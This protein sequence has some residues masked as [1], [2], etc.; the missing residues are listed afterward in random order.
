MIGKGALFNEM[1]SYFASETLDVWRAGEMMGFSAGV[2]ASLL[3]RN[4]FPVSVNVDEKRGAMVRLS[5]L[6]Q[7]LE[8]MGYGLFCLVTYIK[9]IERRNVPPDGTADAYR[10]VRD[11]N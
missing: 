1:K 3:G 10:K 11:G 6:S 7:Y 5:E 9:K 4:E 2:T 8:V